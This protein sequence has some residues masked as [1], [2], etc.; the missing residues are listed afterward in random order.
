MQLKDMYSK[1]YLVR[2]TQVVG[3]VY[4]TFV[5]QQFLDA[6]L[7][8]DWEDLKLMERSDRI[9]ESLHQQ[10]PT[11]FRKASKILEKLAPNFTG[12]AAVCLP[13]YVAKYGLDEWQ[14]SMDLLAIL[15][16]YSTGEFAIRPFLIKYPQKTQQQMLE[17]ST[18]DNTD[19]RRLASEGIRP[20][21]PWGIRLKQYMFDPEPIMP[22]LNNLL[23][24]ESEYVQKSVAN[25]LNDISKD[26][27]EIVIA[28]TQKYWHQ[29]QTVDWVINRGLR[30]LFKQ[31]RPEVLKLLGYDPTLVEQMRKI[32][33]TP[34]KGSLNIGDIS[35]FHY[36]FT[37]A[38]KDE[39]LIYLGYRVH[40]VRQNKADSYKDFFIK[41]TSIK[42]GQALSGNFK[43]K[44]Q[45]LSTRKLYPG[46]HQ[47][48]LLINT[49]VAT[50]SE[51]ELQE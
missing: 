40:Y 24:D 26:N 44:W 30:T 13:N 39:S 17:W 19:I 21:L 35:D 15:T 41:K 11:D 18:S 34:I 31:G 5:P 12:L 36:S 14:I 45:Q 37:S 38:T 22:I 20:R 16:Q 7:T 2:M 23:F 32:Q 8:D 10:F 33:L 25:N 42:S 9:T 48:E 51:I 1:A 6:C 28:F 27:P 3:A 50:S 4:S 43:V 47:V 29:R 49:E 46:L